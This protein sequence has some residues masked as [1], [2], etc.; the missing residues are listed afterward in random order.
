M[1]AL[2]AAEEL[3]AG[4]RREGGQRGEQDHHVSG[5]AAVAV[6]RGED[7]AQHGDVV[8]AAGEDGAGAN[9]RLDVVTN[10]SAPAIGQVRATH[11]TPIPENVDNSQDSPPQRAQKRVGFPS[12][13]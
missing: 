3:G 12:T 5:L 2:G 4:E 9:K 13:Y 1:G 7:V 11:P 6:G 10:D 8:G